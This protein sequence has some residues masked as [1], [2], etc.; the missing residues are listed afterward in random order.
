MTGEIHKWVRF[1]YY[2]HFLSQMKFQEKIVFKININSWLR[3]PF[4]AGRSRFFS[5]N[6]A[7]H[8]EF[9][10][11]IFDRSSSFIRSKFETS[12]GF[13]SKKIIWKASIIKNKAWWNRLM[14]NS[15]LITKVIKIKNLKNKGLNVS[16]SSRINYS[17]PTV[18]MKTFFI[19][20]FAGT[21]NKK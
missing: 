21:L 7:S 13:W 14:W 18:G 20:L 3:Y 11:G 2:S 5:Q 17:T 6:S 1:D 8:P 9:S 19:Q 10:S 12:N 16:E 15:E 4:R